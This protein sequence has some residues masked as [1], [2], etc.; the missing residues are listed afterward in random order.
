MRGPG[1]HSNLGL[2]FLPEGRTV[3]LGLSEVAVR[4]PAVG[5]GED[6]RLPGPLSRPGAALKKPG[7]GQ[8]WQVQ[9]QDR[10][11]YIPSASCQCSHW[12]E[13]K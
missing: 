5:G 6:L 13:I 1:P 10:F 12:E 9:T 2:A 3:A 7:L 8:F 11:H 4:R